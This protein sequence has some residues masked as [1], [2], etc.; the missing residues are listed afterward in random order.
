MG[1]NLAQ[2]SSK[3]PDGETPSPT[4]SQP[5]PPNVNPFW[6]HAQYYSSKKDKEPTKDDLKYYENRFRARMDKM[7]V[8]V[9]K[10]AKPDGS[11]DQ[12][13]RTCRD[14]IAFNPT[15]KSGT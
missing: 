6:A 15:Y 12:P 7:K 9:E 10:L 11:K 5:S 13:A 1:G 3:G 14:L 8:E 4:G 2:G